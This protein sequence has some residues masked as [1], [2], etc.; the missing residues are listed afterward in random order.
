MNSLSAIS[1][2]ASECARGV[3]E[4]YRVTAFWDF[5]IL[6]DAFLVLQDDNHL[7]IPE[8]KVGFIQLAVDGD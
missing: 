6:V 1:G 5:C 3:F 7:K 2:D 8:I 4:A